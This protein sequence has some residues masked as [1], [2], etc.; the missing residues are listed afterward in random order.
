M[1]STTYE[2]L[3]QEIPST[4]ISCQRETH[5]HVIDPSMCSSFRKLILINRRVLE[6]VQIWKQK[7]GIVGN[8]KSSG[9][10][11]FVEASRKII[12]TEQG[13]YFSAI[14][15]YF[16]DNKSNLKDIPHVVTQLNVY[17][18]SYTSPGI[19]DHST[20]PFT[21]VIWRLQF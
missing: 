20:L 3:G 9:L 7:A 10:N 18:S 8:K 19:G 13:R 2:I 12:S 1:D 5:Q 6:C 21:V 14:L 17:S 16:E 4:T 15:S 11:F